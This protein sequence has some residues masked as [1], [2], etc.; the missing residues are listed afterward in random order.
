MHQEPVEQ[1]SPSRAKGFSFS[2][3]L[4]LL[5]GLGLSAV[6]AAVVSLFYAVQG[7]PDSMG[8]MGNY[9]LMGVVVYGSMP[10]VFLAIVLLLFYLVIE[11]PWRSGHRIALVFVIPQVLLAILASI[12]VGIVLRD[13]HNRDADD[14]KEQQRTAQVELDEKKM[15]AA[16]HSDD[17][18]VFSAAYTDC[19][20]SCNRAEWVQSS[21]VANAPRVL[22]VLLQGI[23]SQNYQEIDKEPGPGFCKSGTHYDWVESPARLVGFR[24]SPAITQ[25]FLP[26]WNAVNKDEAFLGA[27]MGGSRDLMESLVAQGVNPRTISNDTATENVYASAADGGSASSI[28]W[29]AAAG[30]TVQTRDEAESIWFKLGQWAIYSSSDVAQKG[31]ETWLAERQKIRFSNGAR[32]SR[33][34]EL[35]QAVHTDSSVLLAAMLKQGYRIKDLSDEDQDRLRTDLPKGSSIERKVVCNT[36]DWTED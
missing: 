24:N 25:Q 28:A 20:D 17:V 23:T 33:A 8:S 29:L 31:V 10:V 32:I 14:A 13:D 7:K 3:I 11:R 15:K 1:S 9:V 16:V 12:G 2:W 18:A 6:A 35:T 4:L 27:A 36:A 34:D 26:L 30:V 19:G 21:V 22:A 5:S